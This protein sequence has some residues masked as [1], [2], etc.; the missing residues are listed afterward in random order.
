VVVT[1]GPWLEP[2]PAP[3]TCRCWSTLNVSSAFGSLEEFQSNA[4]LRHECPRSDR[5]VWSKN[6]N[7]R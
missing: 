2:S 4:L 5:W 6:L 3:R 7:W 1:I